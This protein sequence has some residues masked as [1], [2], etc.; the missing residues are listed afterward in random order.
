MI[1]SSRCR[2]A[3]PSPPPPWRDE[4]RRDETR[5]ADKIQ[6]SHKSSQPPHSTT[7]TI[8]TFAQTPKRA[9][10]KTSL[11]IF[12][13]RI[14]PYSVLPV[15]QKMEPVEPQSPLMDFRALPKIEVSLFLFPFSWT[16]IRR[17]QRWMHSNQS[18]WLPTRG[19]DIRGT[20]DVRLQRGRPFGLHVDPDFLYHLCPHPCLLESACCTAQRLWSGILSLRRPIPFAR[21]LIH[22]ASLQLFHLAL[23][24]TF[25]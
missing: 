22:T 23:V 6:S 17:L 10:P 16:L 18:S 14:T 5:R 2:I 13:N 7:T 15:M 9:L 20:S 1:L 24:C 4:T 21:E 12:D 8:R 25:D 3:S 19:H 11:A